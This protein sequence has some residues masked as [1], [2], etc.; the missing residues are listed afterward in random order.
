V[1]LPAP[2]QKTAENQA[3]S[4]LYLLLP[5]L[6]SVSMAAYMVT[7]GRL[8]MTMLGVGFVVTSVGVTAYVRAQS[9]NASRTTRLR[10]RDRYVEFL[11]DIRAQA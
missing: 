3:S 2:P 5:L 6:S 8:W 4:W 9:R 10:Q 1:P 11:T 7:F